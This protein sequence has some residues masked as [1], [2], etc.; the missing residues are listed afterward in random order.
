M[1]TAKLPE[2]QG[3]TDAGSLYQ[4]EL[5]ALVRSLGQPSYR[6]AQIYGW[7]HEKRVSSFAE[8][9]NLPASLRE[10]LEQT[11]ALP[12]AKTEARQISKADGT[13]KF[14][15]RMVDGQ[16]IES[17]FMPY[18]HGNS[19]CISSQAGCAMGCRFCASAIGGL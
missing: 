1:E 12:E 2:I 9:T 7:L 4:A 14:A 5:E 15:F 16:V 17:V 3:K 18:R 11:A 13:Q 10:K 19:V 8:M 6:A